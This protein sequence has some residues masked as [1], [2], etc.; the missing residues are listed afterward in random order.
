MSL[1][2]SEPAE[3][4]FEPASVLPA[5]SSLFAGLFCTIDIHV[6]DSIHAQ[7]MTFGQVPSC[8]TIDADTPNLW[9]RETAHLYIFARR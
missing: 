9:R 5:A 3:S 7:A 4:K 6:E 2:G 1:A 8:D